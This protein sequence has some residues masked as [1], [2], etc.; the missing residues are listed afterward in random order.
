MA[1]RSTEA[2]RSPSLALRPRRQA[3]GLSSHLRRGVVERTFAWLSRSRRH[4]RDYER[5]PETGEIMIHAAMSCVMLRRIAASPHRRIISLSGQSV[6]W[7]TVVP[8]VGQR[9]AWPATEAEALA[10]LGRF[11]NVQYWIKWR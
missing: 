3:E 5:L 7:C 8:F 11:R 9:R 2:S 10:H 4:S 6:S 1:R